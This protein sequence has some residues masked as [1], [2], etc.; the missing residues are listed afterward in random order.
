M[1]GAVPE[2]AVGTLFDLSPIDR[3]AVV[4][5]RAAI[6]L[7]NPHR[8]EM[9]LL[10]EIVWIAEDRSCALAR[11]RVADDAFW[12]RGHFPG[13]A[14]MPGVLQVEAGA[15]LACY[16]WN[17]QQPVPRVAAFLRIE[18]CAF[19]RSVVPGD[20]LLVL[21]R[22]VKLGRRRFISDVQGVV[23]GQV[24]FEARTTG[25]ALEEHRAE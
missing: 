9:A 5:D 13:H 12:V 17:M 8:F 7:L 15:Q 25:M 1:T 4:A 20:E 24:A 22:E 10:D 14:L 23:S 6:G 11:H 19:R 3:S 18:N 21:C 16:L 2:A